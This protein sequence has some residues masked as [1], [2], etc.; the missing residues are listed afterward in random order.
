MSVSR[1]EYNHVLKFFTEL[2]CGSLGDYRDL[3]LTTYVL[4]LASVCEDFC[5]VCCQIYGSDCAY[6]FTAINLSGDAFLKVFKP[7][8]KLLTDCEH[9]DLVQR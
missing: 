4:L 6:Y 5:E 7:D 2:K 8:L 9:L 1:S 3:Y